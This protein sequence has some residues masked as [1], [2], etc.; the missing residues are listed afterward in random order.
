MGT[1]SES[2]E[3]LGG[4]LMVWGM[5]N[6]IMKKQKEKNRPDGNYG[7]TILITTE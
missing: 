1:G 4:H 2:S 5:E 7:I 3:V 6:R